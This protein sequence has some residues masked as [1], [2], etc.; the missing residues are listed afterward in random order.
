MECTHRHKGFNSWYSHNYKTVN[1]IIGF[2]DERAKRD[3]NLQEENLMK[4]VADLLTM[5]Q[6]VSVQGRLPFR[7]LD[8]ETCD[9]SCTCKQKGHYIQLQVPLNVGIYNHELH[10]MTNIHSIR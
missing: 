6:L 7:P 8:P 2:Q 5:A 4:R 9:H 10:N 1:N 3:L